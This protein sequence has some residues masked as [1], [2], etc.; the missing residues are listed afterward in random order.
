MP[1]M[2]V[3]AKPRI[4]SPPR[5][6]SGKIDSNTVSDVTTV[7]PRVWLSEV[8]QLPPRHRLSL[9]VPPDAVVGQDLSV[10]E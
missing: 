4:A 9:A 10:T 8:D 5:T 2:I 1:K 7:R 6:A 3:S